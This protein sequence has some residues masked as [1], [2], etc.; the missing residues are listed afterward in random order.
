MARIFSIPYQ[1]IHDRIM[2]ISNTFLHG[3]NKKNGKVQ[4]GDTSLV[5]QTNT[6]YL[7]PKE[8]VS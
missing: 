4:Q 5:T 8:A 2:S 1:K 3:M 7:S 6:L